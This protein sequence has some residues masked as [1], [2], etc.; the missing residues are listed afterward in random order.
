MVEN[1]EDMEAYINI[2]RYRIHRVTWRFQVTPY[3]KV[4]DWILTHMDYSHIMLHSESDG[5][6]A[7]Y[8]GEDMSVYYNMVRPTKYVDK[9]F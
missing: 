2:K 4:P 8:Y 5:K 6:L 1:I 7:T 9:K 3:A